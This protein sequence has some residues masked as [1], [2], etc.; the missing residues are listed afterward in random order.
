MSLRAWSIKNWTRRPWFH[1]NWVRERQTWNWDPTLS[2][3]QKTSP[4]EQ[5]SKTGHDA[6]SSRWKWVRESK[7]WKRVPTTSSLPKTTPGVPKKKTGH[8]TLGT[9]KNESGSAMHVNGTRR[10]RYRRKWV[11]ERKTWKRD[12][13]LSVMPKMSP[14]AQ[15]MKTGPGAIF[16]V[17]NESENAKHENGTRR[18]RYRRKCVRESKSCKWDATSSL[19]P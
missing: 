13:T 16:I 15:N 3:P 18:P 4:K 5:N 7:I 17:E 1:S 2:V 10:R 19:P 11:W 12:P 14:K 9:A 8:D 6:L